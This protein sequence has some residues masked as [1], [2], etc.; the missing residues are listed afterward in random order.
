[1]RITIM[2][3]V[4]I[5]VF[6]LA[7]PASARSLDEKA[8]LKDPGRDSTYKVYREDNPEVSEGL[9][10]AAGDL[11]RVRLAPQAGSKNLVLD[12]VMRGVGPDHSRLTMGLFV[13]RPQGRD[14]FALAGRLSI[15]GPS[16]KYRF[17]S[18]GSTDR[19]KPL[20]V[21][22]SETKPANVR[23]RLVL[24]ASCVQNL[25]K[26]EKFTMGMGTDLRVKA[27]SGKYRSVS[28]DFAIGDFPT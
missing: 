24:P 1:M 28:T 12:A 16:V 13:E 8:V 3:L 22:I 26:V 4:S 17:L 10:R 6:S 18:S 9:A 25:R 14:V 2:S 23:V 15:E 21:N 27:P 11:L 19:C 7:T 5:V 20:D